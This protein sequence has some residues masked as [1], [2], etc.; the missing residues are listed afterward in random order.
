MYGIRYLHAISHTL[1]FS[2]YMGNAMFS[3]IPIHFYLNNVWDLKIKLNFPYT[4]CMGF[5]IKSSIPIQIRRND[6]W[7]FPNNN[8]IPYTFRHLAPPASLS[9]GGF[10]TVRVS[11]LLDY[12]LS[13]EGCSVNSAKHPKGL[14]LILLASQI[15]CSQQ[16]ETETLG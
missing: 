9:A 5:H 11:N 3:S 2:S 8:L 15:N 13:V 12:L 1:L 6:V 14:L 7:E 16:V 4:A 10:A